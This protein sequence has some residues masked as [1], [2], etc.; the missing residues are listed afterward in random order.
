MN[1]F[2]YFYYTYNNMFLAMNP[3]MGCVLDKDWIELNAI[4]IK[5]N[6]LKISRYGFPSA[7]QSE[8][9]NVTANDGLSNKFI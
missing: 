1:T 5:L 9:A 8:I 7:E 3:T 2:L 4:N 6:K